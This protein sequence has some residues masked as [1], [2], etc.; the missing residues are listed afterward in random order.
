MNRVYVALFVSALLTPV[1]SS[2]IQ[3]QASASARI[4]SVIAH[5]MR[6]RR[7]PGVAVAVVENGKVVYKRAFGS[8][9]LEAETPM[10]VDAVFELASITKQFTAAAIMLLLQDGKLTLDDSISKFMANPPE[11][12][13]RITV[14][15]LLTHT[16]G[17]DINGL[18]RVQ[19]SAPLRITTAQT[20]DFV[21]Q[22]PMR[23][24]PGEHGWYSD[25]GYFLLGMIIEQASGMSYRQFMQQRIFDPLQ[26]TQSSILDKARILKKRVPTYT[27]MLREGELTNWRRD[28]DHELPAFFGVFST[29]DDLVKWDAVLRTGKLLL[30]TSL[31]QMWTPAKLDNGH[32]ARVLEQLY[33]FGWELNDLAGQRT[34]GHGGASGTYIL[35]FVDQP[36]TV[37]VLTNLDAPS[38][39]RHPALLA[40][41]VAGA[42]KPELR[43]PHMLAPT[44]DPQPNLTRDVQT[45]VADLSARR[46]PA[47]ATTDFRSWYAVNPGY[48]ALAA[49]QLRDVATVTYLGSTA[50]SGRTSWDGLA[51]DRLVYYRGAAGNRTFF[52]TVGTTGDGKVARFDFY[53]YR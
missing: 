49:N 22:Q 23:F 43:P 18:V 30:P 28:W 5:E 14:R 19:G 21:A 12:W 50:M 33:G 40:R 48:R 1:R 53:S 35:R 26:M 4:D 9:N 16:G 34:V 6:T 51:L 27:L 25:A 15:H 45:F 20:F 8:S 7:I 39:G 38:G 46:E 13:S 32:F 42:W 10:T 31:Q 52:L 41:S 37:I 36:L 44:Q 29:L 24:A 17:L 3:S 11:S 47:A 2:A